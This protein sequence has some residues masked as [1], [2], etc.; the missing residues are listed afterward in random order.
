MQSNAG[1]EKQIAILAKA[2][3]ELAEKSATTWDY[4]GEQMIGTGVV[5]EYDTEQE[6]KRI[7]DA[8]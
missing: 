5:L 3:L 4:D 7:I 1:M 2:I 6:L 8:E